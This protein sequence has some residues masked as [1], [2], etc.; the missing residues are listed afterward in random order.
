MRRSENAY[1]EQDTHHATR[2]NPIISSVALSKF[3]NDFDP[4]KVEKDVN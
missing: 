3:E 1:E 4:H 2:R